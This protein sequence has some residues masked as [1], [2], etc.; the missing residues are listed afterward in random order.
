MADIGGDMEIASRLLSLEQDSELLIALFNPHDVLCYANAAFCGTFGVEPDE[1][2]SWEQLMRRGHER[3]H[4]SRIRTDD[5]D[6]WIASARSRRG[7]LPFR[8][9]EADL[10]DGRWIWVT[11]TLQADGWLLCV[12]SD[13]SSLRADERELRI[14]RDAAQRAALTDPLTG[15]SNR[16]HIMGQLERLLRQPRAA[17]S[18]ACVVG[19]L[20]LDHF[21]R[22]NDCYGHLAG[23][24]VL[25]DF[26]RRVQPMLEPKDG[27]GR[28]GGEEFL[29]L[30]PDRALREAE[31][32]V[33]A[34]LAAVA[35]SR[36]LAEPADFAYTCSAG[37][38]LLRAG[39]DTAQALG[40]ADDALYRAK[41]AGRNRLATKL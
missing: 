12:C 10:T 35:E 8:T 14:A 40:R 33:T 26:V 13:I 15:I 23:D 29:L 27:L 18:P 31:L 2:I 24:T 32:M 34:I 25:R 28:L 30:M 6:A 16:A 5:I 41:E 39:D 7:K 22:I 19:I 38:T 4:G 11:E 21:K 17:E 20:D 1:R 36:P 37:L 9:F 3:G